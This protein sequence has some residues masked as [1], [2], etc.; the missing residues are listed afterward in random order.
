M[1]FI[2]LIPARGGSKGIPGKNT[3]LL[4]GVPLVSHTITAAISSLGAANVFVSTD[5]QDIAAIASDMGAQAPFLRP[6]NLSDDKATAFEV[7]EH[8][9]AWTRSESI[10]L[11]AIAYLQPTSPMRSSASITSACEMI[12]EVPADSL[13]SVVPVPHQFT[14]SS[15]MESRD[16]WLRP[17]ESLASAPLRRQDKPQFFARNGPAIL[18]SK[19]A[20]LK[21]HGN[22]YGEKILK[23][24]MSDEES[25]DIDSERDL[26]YADWLLSRMGNQ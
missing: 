13:V 23:F 2:A 21:M 18:I 4:G 22:L 1:K 11:D 15:L 7:V 20:T 19:P 17:C 25:V 8:F 6:A 9:I 16:N 12:E 26:E 14:P 10:D 24:E 5:T 3:R